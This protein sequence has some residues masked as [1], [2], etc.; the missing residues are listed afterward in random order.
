MLLG[1][2][3]DGCLLRFAAVVR[4]WSSAMVSFGVSQREE[5][6]VAENDRLRT[7]LSKA[8]LDAAK[9]DVAQKV[10]HLLVE[11]LHH[12]VKNTLAMVQAIAMQSL[13]TSS[14]LKD[15]KQS[16]AGR[17]VALGKVHDLLLQSNWAEAE[18]R[19]ILRM[20]VSP[21]SAERFVITSP[22]IAVAASAALPLGMVLNELCTNAAKYGALS[23]PN[24]VVQITA[25]VEG[26]GKTLAIRWKES[27]GPTVEPPSRNSFGTRLIEQS[28]VGPVDGHVALDFPPD[29]LACVMRLS[30]KA[31][32]P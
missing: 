7:L 31:L 32:K 9:S 26:G 19:A 18:L 15:A 23:T 25:A 13:S 6:L 5:H 20:A 28:L 22:S 24:G 8:G 12:R 14:S 16:I 1:A 10:Q 21:F 17:L 30:M 4:G 3:L 29:G 27:G 2:E 11:E